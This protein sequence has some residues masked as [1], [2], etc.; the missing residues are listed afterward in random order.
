MTESDAQNLDKNL[1]THREGLFIRLLI[2]HGKIKL[3][4]TA[5]N[6]NPNKGTRLLDR[7]CRCWDAK[8]TYEAIHFGIHYGY[9]EVLKPDRPPSRRS[10]I[11][12]GE[13]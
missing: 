6:L 5:M 12:G 9:G 10:T 11:N 13:G 1:L 2:Q 3:A 4:S 7:I 8:N